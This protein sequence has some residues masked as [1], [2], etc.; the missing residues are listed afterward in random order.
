M[1]VIPEIRNNLHTHSAHI[2]YTYHMIFLNATPHQIY[3]LEIIIIFIA[4][5]FD[6]VLHF[7]SPSSSVVYFCK[8]AHNRFYYTEIY[9]M[10]WFGVPGMGVRLVDFVYFRST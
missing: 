2:K 8:R 7:F 10:C 4:I 1:Q 3:S 6:T 5:Q 9:I